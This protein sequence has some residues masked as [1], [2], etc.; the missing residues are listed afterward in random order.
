MTDDALEKR[1]LAEFAS[2]PPNARFLFTCKYTK[3]MKLNFLLLKVC[4]LLRKEKG[5]CVS[6]DRPHSYTQ[7]ALKKQNVPQDGLIYIDAIT[8]L[9]GVRAE[10]SK[11][12]FLASGYSPR[13]LSD[14][15]SRAYLAEGVQRYFVNLDELN[16]ILLDN[17]AVMLQYATLEKTRKFMVDLMEMLKKFTAMR[18]IL[19]VD[20]QTS[21]EVLAIARSFCDREI[22]VMDEW[23]M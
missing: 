21:G 15:F 3:I 4:L 12:T 18:A 11:V 6:I 16:F 19:V 10:E 14:L 8:K 2:S 23:L 13:I 20:P 22:P 5:M 17:I 7:M 1:V 9:A